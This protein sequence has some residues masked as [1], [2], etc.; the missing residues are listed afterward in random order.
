MASHERRLFIVP[1]STP[2]LQVKFSLPLALSFAGN[3]LSRRAEALA[4]TQRPLGRQSCP[5]FKNSFNRVG[6]V[7]S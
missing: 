1:E 6:A 2:E 3:Y 5:T 7:D 4:K